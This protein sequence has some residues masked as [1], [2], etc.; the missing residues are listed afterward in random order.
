[1]SKVR[2]APKFFAILAVAGALCAGVWALL[3]REHSLLERAA[4]ISGSDPAGDFYWLNER[5]I[6]SVYNSGYDH[7]HVNRYDVAAKTKTNLPAV[8]KAMHF[9]MEGAIYPSADGRQ[10]LCPGWDDGGDRDAHIVSLDTATVTAVDTGGALTFAWHP[11]AASWLYFSEPGATLVNPLRPRLRRVLPI[12][13]SDFDENQASLL[14][15]T[16]DN[17]LLSAGVAVNEGLGDLGVTIA[18]WRLEANRLTPSRQY[19]FGAALN[20]PKEMS[21]QIY[22]AIN[23]QGDRI[24]WSQYDTPPESFLRQQM[25]RIFPGR[26]PPTKGR[27]ELRSAKLDGSDRVDFGFIEMRGEEDEPLEEIRFSPDGTQIG[28][29]YGG[30]IYALPAQ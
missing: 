11:G 20:K 14:A 21:V 16:P 1:M 27:L 26:F 2:Q 7:Y 9:L 15:V 29:F 30:A 18:E 4:K 22:C 6:L 10:F 24:V 17:R 19:K 8:E 3:P 12:T 28:F 13:P 25:R 5:E 23:P